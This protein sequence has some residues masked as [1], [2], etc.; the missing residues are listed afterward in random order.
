MSMKRRPD[1]DLNQDN[2]NEE[3]EPEVVGSFEKASQEEMK[4][5]IIKTAKRRTGKF[6]DT[7]DGSGSETP[8]TNI[9]FGFSGFNKANDAAKPAAALFNFGKKS[10]DST[11]IATSKPSMAFESNY[12][13]N[14]ESTPVSQTNGTQK[15]A[16]YCSKL[17]ELNSAFIKCLKSHVDTGKLCILTPILNDYIKFVGEL[18]K[19]PTSSATIVSTTATVFSSS[20]ASSVTAAITSKPDIAAAPSTPSLTS[21]LSQ[22]KPFSFGTL[23]STPFSLKP[24]GDK[25]S[26]FGATSATVTPATQSAENEESDENKE[27]EEP[28]VEFTPVV[29][30]DSLFDIR[31]KVFVK[32]GSD[33]TS[34]GTG[35]LYLK[36]VANDKIQLLVR[37]DTN[38]GN[39]L[40][41]Y[42]LSAAIPAKRLGKNN[43]CMV[44]IPTPESEPK[45]V[46]ILIRVKNE[47]E[48]DKLL[49]QITKNSK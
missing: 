46:P 24:S 48:A 31:C 17:K 32:K 16:E 1:S 35:T 10:D 15:S 20:V 38:L 3:D 40:L 44:C 4:S 41:N 19:T 27:D 47:E 33:Y 13:L 22:P 45:P 8:K 5:R 34:R 14:V 39:V 12:N 11:A 2:W 9:F 18:E 23:G 29:E 21:S 26:L 37:A 6:G 7:A 30:D 42:L 28:K 49:N 25:P 43:V 36:P